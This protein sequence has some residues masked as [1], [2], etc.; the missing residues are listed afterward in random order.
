MDTEQSI[1]DT[2]TTTD[3]PTSTDAQTTT[4]VPT[5]T[6]TVETTTWG[7]DGECACECE[8]DVCECEDDVIDVNDEG[9]DESEE[10]LEDDPPKVIYIIRVNDN[11][12][13]FSYSKDYAHHFVHNLSKILG[14][15][16]TLSHTYCQEIAPDHIRIYET[17]RFMY[18]LSY[19]SLLY[20]ITCEPVDLL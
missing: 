17:R 16:N 15:H 4:D 18:L 8:G 12:S 14:H 20:R 10:N 6:D 11:I 13:G 7:N 9:E 2:Q 1:T 19:D 5:S 3:V